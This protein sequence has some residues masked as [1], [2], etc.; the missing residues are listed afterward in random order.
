MERIVRDGDDVVYAYVGGTADPKYMRKRLDL[1]VV[2]WK[3]NGEIWVRPS[4]YNCAY[5]QL[6]S[7]FG[8]N[9]FRHNNAVWVQTHQTFRLRNGTEGHNANVFKR[10]ATHY[11]ELMNPVKD[12]RLYLKRKEANNVRSR[13]KEFRDYLRG[14]LKLRDGV[15]TL[16]ECLEMFGDKHG[17]KHW[18]SMS[19]IYGLDLKASTHWTY[20]KNQPSS[21]LPEFVELIRSGNPVNFYRASLMMVRVFGEQSWG[22]SSERLLPEKVAMQALDRILFA[23]HKDEVFQERELEYGDMNRGAWEW[24]KNLTSPQ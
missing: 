18:W 2:R 12:T 22:E 17:V 7:M 23:T 16:A 1:Y 21:A 13:Y 5:D 14:T 24:V 8:L 4:H 11:L 10:G 19:S 20:R 3:P 9:F 6:S 15:F